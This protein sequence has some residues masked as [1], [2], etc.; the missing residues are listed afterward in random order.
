MEGYQKNT[1][2][3]YLWKLWK[4]LVMFSAIH[5][6]HSEVKNFHNFSH[7]CGIVWDHICCQ[8]FVFCSLLNSN[9]IFLLCPL[10]FR[11]TFLVPWLVP[12]F[13][14]FAVSLIYGEIDD[15]SNVAKMIS[16]GIPLEESYVQHRLSVLMKEEKSSLKK[17]K[18][19]IPDSYYL[20]GTADPTGS[21][22]KDEVCV[23]LY[24]WFLLLFSFV[25]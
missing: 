3:S 14:V 9:V 23:I 25:I 21:L 16:C 12:S 24:A 2:W 8:F 22:E 4:I 5:A 13:S 17:G 7:F 1:S 19:C 18:I 20:M 6:Q 15:N 10:V 11:L